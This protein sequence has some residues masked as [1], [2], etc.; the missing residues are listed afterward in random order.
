MKAVTGFQLHA[1]ASFLLAAALI[2]VSGT[3]R[4]ASGS[5]Q[6]PVL[7]EIRGPGQP[8]VLRKTFVMPSDGSLLV[9][10][11]GL[12]C[13][14]GQVFLAAA[15]ILDEE[16]REAVWIMQDAGGRWNGMTENWEVEDTISLTAGTYTAFF[17]GYGGRL[18]I[19]RDIRLFG[20]Q[21]GR[22]RSSVAPFRDWGEVGD[23]VRWGIRV[24]AIDPDFTPL[25]ATDHASVPF[26]DAD[27]RFL[28]LGTMEARRARIEVDRPVTFHLRFTGEYG[29]RGR[30]FS[31][32]AWL[33]DALTWTRV[34]EPSFDNTVPAGGADKNRCF[35]GTIRL[36][37]GSYVLTAMT[38]DSHDASGWN[39]LP[40]LDPESWGVSMTVAD[41][42]DSEAFRVCH[43]TA[44]PEPVISIVRQGDDAFTRE[45]FS[46]DAP[47]DLLVRAL[48]EAGRSR[49]MVDY[50]WIEDVRSMEALWVMSYD[51]TCPSGGDTRNR[52]TE[53]VLGVREGDYALCYVTD[54]SHAY[55]IWNSPPPWEPGNWGVTLAPV[56]EGSR[57]LVRAGEA[58]DPPEVH[59]L[60][61][62][63]NRQDLSMRFV[64]RS[65]TRF[66]LVALGEGTRSEMHDYGWIG[67]DDGGI[68]WKMEYEDTQHAG[69]A[70]K[71][72]IVRDVIELPAGGYVMRYVSDG[73]HAFG[74]W[75][76]PRPPQPHLWG[77]TLVEVR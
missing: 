30:F 28:G 5:A 58:A 48:G 13:E 62:V 75:N 51:N 22:L 32:S 16:T 27:V 34:W 35:R 33:V 64:L 65:K 68:V 9:E 6:G 56:D 47:A 71:N 50:A 46:L 26:A 74:S 52:L 59:S 2:T 76:Q 49:R 15:W 36:P 18:P 43:D 73:S 4:V 20:F 19:E 29:H 63:R 10:A 77:L 7:A 44:L 1:A 69:G 25:P 45:F 37:A 21:I 11:E 41:A 66:R 40:P 24:Q 39:V 72:R 61:P 53:Q 31:D 67:S 23:P 57:H 8:G 17:A 42:S 3:A 14:R 54:D 55:Q 60:A 38:D 12:A 70:R